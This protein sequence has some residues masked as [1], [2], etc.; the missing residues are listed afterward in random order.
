MNR[1][2]P[3]SR[4]IASVRIRVENAIRRLKEFKIFTD[5]LSNRINKKVLD[6]MVTISCALCNLKSRLIKEK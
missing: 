3:E 6:D 5:T 1:K 2:L 4:T